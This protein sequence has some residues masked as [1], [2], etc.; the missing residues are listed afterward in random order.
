MSAARM[1]KNVSAVM[2]LSLLSLAL[3]GCWLLPKEQEADIPALVQPPDEEL[4]THVLAVGPISEE[5]I[6][7]AR[8]GSSREQALYFSTAGRIREVLVNY[9]D[10]V[11]QGQVLI[12]ME[13]GQLDF[14][15]KRAQINLEQAQLRLL[16]KSQSSQVELRLAKLDLELAQ[17]EVD[18]L[19]ALRA[20]S[21]LRAPFDGK[22]VS[23]TAMRGKWYEAYTPLATISSMKGLEMLAEISVEQILRIKPGM[24]VKVAMDEGAPRF[25]R[26]IILEQK[27]KTETNADQKWI[28][29]IRM[30]DAGFPLVFDDYYSISFLLRTSDKALLVPNDAV[31]EDVNGKKYLRVIEGKKRR[32]VYIKTGIESI[33]TEILEGA[34]PGMTV[35]G[36]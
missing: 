33:E 12:A 2:V 15:I 23:L 26:V 22:V 28:A 20:D 6:G 5:I 1:F 11:K 9:G 3:M 10:T 19:Q 35:I 34:E 7:T 32:D 4:V 18:R 36:R 29:H 8:V 14:E 27:E 17:L 25:G 24:R 13:T 31:R 21:V 30:D 16:M